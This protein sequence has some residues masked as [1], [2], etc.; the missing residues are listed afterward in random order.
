M[1]PHPDVT[2]IRI[3]PVDP[4]AKALGRAATAPAKEGL[5]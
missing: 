1:S 2:V 5:R 3:G 4:A